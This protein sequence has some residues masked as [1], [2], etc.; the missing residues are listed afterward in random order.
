MTNWK[1]KITTLIST[2]KKK[3]RFV[4][5]HYCFNKTDLHSFFIDMHAHFSQILKISI[6]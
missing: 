2:G 3:W 6:A 4:N 5:T 1:K